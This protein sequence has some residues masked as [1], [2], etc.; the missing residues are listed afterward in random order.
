MK[1][2]IDNAIPYIKGILEPYAE[3]LY[4]E[5]IDFRQEDV[6]DADL[7]IIRTRTRCNASLLDSSSV[8]MIATAT[9]GFDH[10]DLEYCQKHGIEVITAQG[11]NA[12][13]VLQWVAAALA[14]LSRKDGW[15]PP[16]R[17]LGIVGVGHVGR[18]VE[19]YARA[20][21]FNV[22][23]CDPPR[24]ERE[25]GDFIPLE[26]LLSRSDI[27]T[28][29][30]PL[31]RTTHHLIN[32][33]TMALMHNDAVL[34]NASRGEV[35]STKTLLNAPQRLLIDV[36]E[37]EPEINRDLL[38]KAIV[39]TPHIAGYSS[40]GKANATAMVVR[41]AAKRFSLPLTDWYPEQVRI[42]ERQDIDWQTMCLTIQSHCDLDAESQRLK[43]APG[44]FESMR[45]GYRYREE[46]F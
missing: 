44:S 40:Q 37:H 13:G 45:N 9:I 29:H 10:I 43:A 12:A 11:C 16:Q 18:L 34:I 21:G 41:A 38:A 35:V 14:L 23:R 32:D 25:G 42:T 1:V 39:T 28:L 8:K 36:W 26:E 33:R 19:Q 30:T 24:K 22:L 27:V 15:T 6:A 31:D 3:V 46:Y 7:L 4:R 5:G 17:T 2:V 20:W